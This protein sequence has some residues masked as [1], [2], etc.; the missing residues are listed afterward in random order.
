VALPLVGGPP[1]WRGGGLPVRPKAAADIGLGHQNVYALVRS[2]KLPA[3][4][5]G[6]RWLVA[7]A[8]LDAFIER[9][10]IKPGELA[11]LLPPSRRGSAGTLEP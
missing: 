11:H 9:S 2:A 8:D 1:C 3:R 10:R 5:R 7:V 6:N 4:R